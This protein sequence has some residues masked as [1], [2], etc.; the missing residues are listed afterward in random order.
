MPQVSGT[1]TFETLRNDPV[2][3]AEALE[4]WKV[5]KTGPYVANVMN[6]IGFFRLDDDLIPEDDPAAGPNTAH[7]EFMTCVCV[8]FD[9]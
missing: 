6:H 4:E 8:F 3:S 1:E 5:N 2:A 7:Y 9:G